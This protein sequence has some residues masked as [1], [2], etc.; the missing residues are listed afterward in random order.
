MSTNQNLLLL[1]ASLVCAT[2]AATTTT[3]AATYHDYYDYYDYYDYQGQ[4][5]TVE[6]DGIPTKKSQIGDTK[7]PELVQ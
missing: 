2:T 5:A 7:S 1:L 3:T 6:D 4:V